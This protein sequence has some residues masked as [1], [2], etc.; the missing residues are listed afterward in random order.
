MIYLVSDTHALQY[1]LWKMLYEIGEI[2]FTEN[3]YV[4]VLG[5]FAYTM[6][7]DGRDETFLRVLSEKPYTVC[8]IDGNHENFERI[9]SLP[10]EKWRGGNVH[11]LKQNVI[12]L[13]RGQIFEI[14][15]KRIFTMGGGFSIDREK[16]TLGVS[17]FEEEMPSKDE[18]ATALMNLK[19]AGMSVDYIFT[20]ASPTSVIPTLLNLSGRTRRTGE[21]ELDD[22]LEKIN[23]SVD[24]K[25]WYFGHWHIDAQI[26]EKLFAVYRKPLALK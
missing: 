19:N 6:S 7:R 13:M 20:H 1:E 25:G 3:D 17:Y 18:Y 12:H 10:V 8:F 11:K 5:D 4:I 24:F 23:S 21:E 9:N 16:R 15:G 22:F 26:S 2:N 14:D